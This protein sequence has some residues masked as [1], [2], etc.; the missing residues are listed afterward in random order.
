[1]S[2]TM[3]MERRA[4]GCRAWGWAWAGAMGGTADAGQPALDDGAALH[5]KMEKCTGGMKI[6]CICDDKMSAG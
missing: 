6:N 2:S 5:H 1:M 4:W 3:M